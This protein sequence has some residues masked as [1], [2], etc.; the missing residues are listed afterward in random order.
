MQNVDS[1]HFSQIINISVTHKSIDSFF[2]YFDIISCTH[3]ELGNCFAK[4][5]HSLE[6]LRNC[7]ETSG[8][9]L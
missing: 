9:F 8:H 4:A 7:F 6:K 5:I 2:K 1:V 3:T